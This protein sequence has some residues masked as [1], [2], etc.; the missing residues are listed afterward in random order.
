LAI[1][2]TGNRFHL[3]ICFG[4]LVSI[5]NC[6]GTHFSPYDTR[7]IMLSTQAYALLLG[8]TVGLALVLLIGIKCMQYVSKTARS[9]AKTYENTFRGF[10]LPRLQEGL[11]ILIFLAANLFFLINGTLEGIVLRSGR[12]SAINLTLLSFGYHMSFLSYLSGL[13]MSHYRSIHYWGAGTMTSE[14]LAHTT[15]AVVQRTSTGSEV[16]MWAVC[17]SSLEK[18]SLLIDY[19]DSQA[20]RS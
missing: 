20:F 12:L 1:I 5:Y 11:P 19:R 10:P 8:Y 4:F 7:P 16:A 2:T 9:L 18:G 14:V 6:K 3:A 15:A 17:P 13:N